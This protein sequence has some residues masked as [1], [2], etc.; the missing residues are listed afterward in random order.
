LISGVLDGNLKEW[1]V[2]DVVLM[3]N[4]IALLSGQLG[5]ESAEVRLALHFGNVMSC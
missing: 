3:V 1:S 2:K 5:A 4:M